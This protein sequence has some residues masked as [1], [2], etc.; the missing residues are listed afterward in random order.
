[1]R[2]VIVFPTYNRQH[3]AQRLVNQ[4]NEQE[5]NHEVEIMA[6]VDGSGYELEGCKTIQCKHHGKQNYWMLYNKI[7]DTVHRKYD[8]IIYLADDITLVD[9]FVDTAVQKFQECKDKLHGVCLSLLTD[10]RVKAPNW[11]RFYPKSAGEYIQTQWVDMAMIIDNDFYRYVGR[12]AKMHHSRWVANPNKSSGVGEHLSKTA[13]RKKLKLFHLKEGLI[14]SGSNK[15]VMNR[16][17]RIKHPLHKYP[18]IAGMATY[19]GRE[20]C[21]VDAYRSI[22]NQVDELHVYVNDD[23]PVHESMINDKKVTIHRHPKGDIG[24]RGKFY[25]PKKN[26]Y[27][28]TIDDDLIYPRDYVSKTLEGLQKHGTVVTWH[29]RNINKKADRYYNGGHEKYR[30]L[31]YVKNDVEVEFPGT[32]VMAWCS[33][34]ID[35]NMSDFKTS[36]MADVYAGIK[37]INE[38]KRAVC[39]AHK[40][41]WII[42]SSRLNINDTIALQKDREKGH[43]KIIKEL[44]PQLY[45]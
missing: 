14:N 20:K 27:Y 3:L 39:L 25:L 45:G 10:K 9:R 7:M 35:F 4:I 44:C 13:H 16:E 19:T 33:D 24:D 41:G 31:G 1:M 2:V 26:A 22:I 8:Y 28:F 32:G 30:C 12:A 36:N 21:R 42:H 23:S 18:K 5:T 34:D 29:G 38:G 40:N 37:I 6:F 17:E 43:I 11:T 15:S